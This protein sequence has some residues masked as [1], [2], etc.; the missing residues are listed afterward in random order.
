MEKIFLFDIG[1]V[2]FKIRD[3]DELYKKLECKCSYEEFYKFFMDSDTYRAS[4]SGKMSIYDYI[5]TL[6]KV[7]GSSVSYEKYIEYH[8]EVNGVVYEDTIELIKYLKQKGYKVG[9]LSNLKSIDVDF[10]KTIFDTNTLDYEF[11]SCYIHSM[12][13]N[14]EIYEHVSNVT[15]PEENEVYFFDDL[16]ENCDAA[17]KFGIRAINTAGVTIKEDYKKMVESGVINDN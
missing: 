12:K 10:F 17:K 15:N 7:T 13:P 16:K 4:E 11:Y 3:I 1:N 8:N 6:K 9:V 14:D 5:D 2:I